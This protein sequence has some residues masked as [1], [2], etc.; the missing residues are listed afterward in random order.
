MSAARPAILIR[1][2][3]QGEEQM[4]S[5]VFKIALTLALVCAFGLVT[6]AQTPAPQEAQ[7]SPRAERAEKRAR[8]GRHKRAGEFGRKSARHAFRQLNLTDAQREQFRAIRERYQSGFQTPRQELRQLAEVRRGGG[9]LT[10]EQLARAQELHTQLRAHN[11]KMRAEMQSLLTPEQQEQLKQQ[12]E[13][14]QQRRKESRQ[15]RKE[16]RGGRFGLPPAAPPINNNEAA[17]Q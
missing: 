15:L 1:Q 10:P 14:L 7:P 13:L 4:K 8:F 6:F 17:A 12:R 3:F 11:E 2:H 5:I 9:T 16:R